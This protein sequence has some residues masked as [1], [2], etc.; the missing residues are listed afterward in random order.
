LLFA[1][2]PGRLQVAVWSGL[3]LFLPWLLLKEGSIAGEWV[4]PDRCSSVL[5]IVLCVVWIAAMCLWRDSFFPA[6]NRIRQAAEVVIGFAAV[7]AMVFVAQLFWNFWQVRTLNLPRATR[8]ASPIAQAVKPKVIWIVLDELSY[9]QVYERRFPGLNLPAFDSLA[10]QSTVFTHVI[11]AGAYTRDVLPS[12]MTGEQLAEVKATADGAQLTLLNLKTNRRQNFDSRETIFQDAYNDG[13]R[14]AIAG[15]FIPYCR[16]LPGI[17]DQCFWTYHQG[18][19]PGATISSE[20][21]AFWRPILT[22]VLE[23]IRRRP[24]TSPSDSGH[25]ADY[26][27]L[28]STGDRF[29]SDPSLNFLLLHMPIPHPRGIYDRRIRAFGTP[30][31][32]YIDNLALADLYLNHVHLLLEQR[33]EWDSAT[34]VIMGDH[35][36]R[37]KW[38][39]SKSALWTAEDQ[40]ASDGAQFDDR[41][42]YIVKLPHQAGPARIDDPFPAVETRALLREILEGRIASPRS[43]RPSPNLNPQTNPEADADQIDPRIRQPLSHEDSTCFCNR[44]SSR[45]TASHSA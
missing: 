12:L 34:I 43:W 26:R 8:P 41:P 17:L 21:S 24:Q 10:Q 30:G 31:T 1:R 45:H 27:E 40:A 11:P 20:M 36:W 7:T 6:F 39:W 4:L 38:M 2:R 13:F 14:T 15:W 9:R 33:G 16:M 19:D 25:L 29:L 5:L 23:T 18:M 35:S 44:W 37:T 3:I 22:D 42:A 32:S 28:L